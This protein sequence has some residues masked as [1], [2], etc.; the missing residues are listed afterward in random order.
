[1][2]EGGHGIPAD[3]I[4]RRYYAGIA[5]FLKFYLPLADELEIYDNSVKRVQIAKRD[6]GGIVQVLDAKRWLKLTRAV[7]C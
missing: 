6:E 7:E 1:M 4:R 5:N 3:V 2:R